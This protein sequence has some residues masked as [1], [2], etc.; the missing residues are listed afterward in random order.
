VTD[1]ASDHPLPGDAIVTADDLESGN[2]VYVRR[3][4]TRRI[5]L[6][7]MTTDLLP[8]ITGPLFALEQD[9]R[10]ASFTL[11]EVTRDQLD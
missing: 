10:S 9:G 7:A 8:T 6:H 3:V 2:I 1:R 4:G 5:E 11:K